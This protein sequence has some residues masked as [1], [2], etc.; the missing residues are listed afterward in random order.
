MTRLYLFFLSIVL[1]ALCSSAQADERYTYTGYNFQTS[2]LPCT[3]K[4]KVTGYFIVKQPLPPNKTDEIL[5]SSYNCP[6]NQ[7]LILDYSFTDGYQT[8]IS[9]DH[10]STVTAPTWVIST[11]PNSNVT[12]WSI[13]VALNNGAEI[14]SCKLS[15]SDAACQVIGGVS[16][17]SSSGPFFVGPANLG[18]TDQMGHWRKWQQVEAA[19]Q[20]FPVPSVTPYPWIIFLTQL[21]HF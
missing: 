21:F 17:D 1:I 3:S 14:T 7:P 5:C 10:G 15:Q 4:C 12:A 9:A 19:P 2:T 20:G 16:R 11:D 18:S 13:G 8:I 6:A